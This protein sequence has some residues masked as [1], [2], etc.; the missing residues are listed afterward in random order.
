MK[1]KTKTFIK[2]SLAMAILF[3]IVALALAV[4]T[5]PVWMPLLIISLIR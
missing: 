1:A 2:D 5:Y 4:I 3:T